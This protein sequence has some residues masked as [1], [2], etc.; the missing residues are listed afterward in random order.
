[1][2]SQQKFFRFELLVALLT[3]IA[4]PLYAAQRPNMVLIVLDDA[5]YSDLGVHG[6]EIDT[7]HI[8]R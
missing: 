8:D 2:D 5:A 7:P 1:M 4:S 3:L 6:G